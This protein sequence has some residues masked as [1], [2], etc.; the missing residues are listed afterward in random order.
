MD[1]STLLDQFLSGLLIGREETPVTGEEPEDSVG[2]VAADQKVRQGLVVFKV[3]AAEGTLE[4]Y[5]HDSITYKMGF[6]AHTYKQILSDP[7]SKV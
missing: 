2:L 4:L 7:L 3:F 6:E 1:L 5:P